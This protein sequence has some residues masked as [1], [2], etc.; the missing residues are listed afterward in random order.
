MAKAAR[1]KATPRSPQ[2]GDNT[3]KKLSIKNTG[4]KNIAR[5]KAEA[6]LIIESSEKDFSTETAHHE[7]K[8]DSS[9]NVELESN[10]SEFIDLYIDQNDTPLKSSLSYILN[11]SPETPNIIYK[12]TVKRNKNV[13]TD[14]EVE[15]LLEGYEKYK[16]EGNRWTKILKSYKFNNRKPVDLKDKHRILTKNT[17]YHAHKKKQYVLVDENRNVLYDEMGSKKTY[18]EKFP[19]EAANRIAKDLGFQNDKDFVISFIPSLNSFYKYNV[20][21]TPDGQIKVLPVSVKYL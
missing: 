20:K 6:F 7:K 9:L 4:I 5:K 11:K 19:S 17:S 14:M 12:N 15:F 8:H 13:W 21:R 16:D 3:E 2:K 18:Y 1:K 10:E